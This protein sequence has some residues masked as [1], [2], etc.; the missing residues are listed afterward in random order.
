M[1]LKRFSYKKEY[2]EVY[3]VRFL[4]NSIPFESQVLLHLV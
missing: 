3:E 2:L 4:S 1:S